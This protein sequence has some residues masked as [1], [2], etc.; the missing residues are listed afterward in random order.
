MTRVR[1]NHSTIKAASVCLAINN[2]DGL[3]AH[4]TD[5]NIKVFCEERGAKTLAHAF[6]LGARNFAAIILSDTN[7]TGPAVVIAE[8]TLKCDIRVVKIDVSHQY[9]NEDFLRKCGGKIYEVFVFDACE[10]DGDK[11]HQKLM[12][13]YVEHCN[14]NHYI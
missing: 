1:K 12:E 4:W 5:E 13:E 7:R 9:D 10:D 2:N 3:A 14:A 6:R 8:S 11:I